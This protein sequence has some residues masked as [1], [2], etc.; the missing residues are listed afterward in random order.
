MS[1]IDLLSLREMRKHVA[2]A[3]E[4]VELGQYPWA[5]REMLLARVCSAM[6]STL[7]PREILSILGAHRA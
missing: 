5:K 2:R 6:L 1:N 3:K 4:L 7:S